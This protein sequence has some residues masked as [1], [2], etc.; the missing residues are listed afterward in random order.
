LFSSKSPTVC[1]AGLWRAAPALV[2]DWPPLFE[3][4]PALVGSLVRPPIISAPG[5]PSFCVPEV[6]RPAY[7]CYRPGVH[8]YTGTRVHGYTATWVLTFCKVPKDPHPRGESSRQLGGHASASRQCSKPLPS[9]K[10]KVM[11]CRSW[12]RST[13]LPESFNVQLAAYVLDMIMIT[14]LEA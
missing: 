10:G 13:N 2:A 7:I 12:I 14:S 9:S 11:P 8:G 1:R 4:S 5:N 3:D 6:L